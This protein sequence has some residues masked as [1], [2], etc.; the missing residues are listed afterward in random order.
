[1]RR[2]AA[3]AAFTMVGL[4]GVAEADRL[5]VP[6]ITAPAELADEAGSI[7]L[8]VRSS[9]AKLAP[10]KVTLVDPA[11]ADHTATGELSRA[12]T[13]L[14]LELTITTRGGGSETVA[15]VAGDGD[16][17]AL[18]GGMVE[19]LGAITHTTPQ[20]VR[21]FALGQLRPYAAALRIA[22]ADPAGAIALL[23]DAA[24]SVAL[25]VPAIP[26]AFGELLAAAP[27]PSARLVVAR[28]VGATDAVAGIGAGKDSVAA[29]ARAFAAIDRADLATAETELVNVSGGLA[30]LGRATI[31]AEHDDVRLGQLLEEA[32]SG[33]QRRAA[34]AL[35]STIVPAHV[36][37]SVHRALLP[38][39]ERAMA[40][41]PGVASRIGF[42]AAQAKVEA[43]R[44]LALV[45][46][47]ELDQ[48]AVDG[49]GAILDAHP[50]I[51]KP[52]LLRLRA[53]LAMRKRSGSVQ[54]AVDAYLAAAPT[55]PRAQKYVA[56][57]KLPP[58]LPRGTTV[59][60]APMN[61]AEDDFVHQVNEPRSNTIDLVLP[62][63][64]GVGVLVL[65]TLVLL[66]RRKRRAPVVAAALPMP[67]PRDRPIA[68]EVSAPRQTSKLKIDMTT[69]PVEPAAIEVPRTSIARAL[70]PSSMQA[71]LGDRLQGLID[72]ELPADLPIARE[73]PLTLP[74]TIE[75]ASA[76]RSPLDV[77]RQTPMPMRALRP[78]ALEVSSL[79]TAFADA[80]PLGGA[81]PH[82]LDDVELG[83]PD[84]MPL[85]SDPKLQFPS[86][87]APGRD[88]MDLDSGPRADR[89]GPT[90]S[91]PALEH[92]NLVR[93]G[94]RA[95][96]KSLAAILAERRELPWLEAVGLIDQV[97][98]GLAHA[99][100]QGVVH[101]GVQPATIFVAGRVAR[102]GEFHV[103]NRPPFAAPDRSGKPADDL[104]AVGA[105]LAEMLKK[106]E[107]PPKL[108]D[109]VAALRAPA[110]AGR[111]SSI[112]EVRA[113]FKALFDF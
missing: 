73:K 55:E 54:A 104:Y 106:G 64:A 112:A 69:P 89:S 2:I 108:A 95:E 72:V 6:A 37:P 101:G 81:S 9:L 59:V 96:G 14:E 1:M 71:E 38:L 25:G 34:L 98:A 113:A 100:A 83:A 45:S 23:A 105:T 90:Q 31:A 26:L 20:P 12:G 44:S 93:P 24:P 75:I 53:E 41:S 60:V 65:V 5:A 110:A 29:A 18:A 76:S 30:A 70:P 78:Q 52:T 107:V 94:T 56:W 50:D 15:I 102:L 48:Y 57:S 33:D 17:V 39:A 68:I 58:R 97:C 62:I 61:A 67:K 88:L 42:A 35:A 4:G 7:D 111:P 43:A 21:P 79:L 80:D 86:G 85:G 11:S 46:V 22:M 47:R 63:I 13:G 99:H 3:L 103:V 28:A 49:L 10:A 82:V 32:L 40:T 84:L 77:D 36:S 16:I 66:Q 27:T 92:A 8:L 87:S 19:K 74:P 51:A 109:L 91:E